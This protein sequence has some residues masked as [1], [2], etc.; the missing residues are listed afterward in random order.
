MK[1]SICQMT[2]IIIFL[3][4]HQVRKWTFQ[5]SLTV[6]SNTE[7][8]QSFFLVLHYYNQILCFFFFHIY[9]YGNQAIFD[10]D[11]HLYDSSFGTS[12]KL[13]VHCWVTTCFKWNRNQRIKFAENLIT[14]IALHKLSLS[15]KRSR[16]VVK[17]KL[18]YLIVNMQWPDVSRLSKLRMERS[19]RQR[20]PVSLTQTNNLN[21]YMG[22][23]LLA[24][25]VVSSLALI[26]FN[27]VF[28]CSFLQWQ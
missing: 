9:H 25:P 27:N 6:P 5:G 2:P 20:L 28:C 19:E 26:C 13:I 4:F 14:K 18:C 1:S 10:N 12:D 16:I 24:G 21:I 11:D 8:N 17:W 15:F 3:R 7:K 23:R 22:F